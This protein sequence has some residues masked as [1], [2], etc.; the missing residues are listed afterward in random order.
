[1][2]A[3]KLY[4]DYGP[5]ALVTGASDG[6]GEA[7]ARELAEAGFDLV[8]CARRADRLER[9]ANA[10]SN[11]HGVSVESLALDL[12]EPSSADMIAAAVQRKDVGLFVGAAGFGTSG[13]VLDIDEADE[14]A[15]IDLN[16]R[17][18]AQQSLRLAKHMVQRGRGGVVLM[19]SLLAFQGVAHA[20]NYAA[21]K[22]FVQGLA[23][24]LRIELKP[25]GVDV[26]ACAPGPVRSGFAARADMQMGGAVP[27]K[28]IPRPTL[29]ALG[30]RTTARPG[31]L[32]KLLS[33]SLATLPRGA[34]S[35]ILT[36]A[37][38]KMTRHQ[39]AKG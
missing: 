13:S 7:F 35:S 39:D 12:S 18:L 20:A 34:R 9:L 11:E 16:C 19:S 22:A 37:M 31:F 5:A 3:K 25:K 15:M 30:K 6:I 26:I 2:N 27:A 8:L 21:T 33:Y 36:D 29:R 38:D 14:L 23:E 10:L 24:G 1:M 28:A 17:A 32:T 4:A